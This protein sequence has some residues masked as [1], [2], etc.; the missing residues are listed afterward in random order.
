MAL[1]S[2]MEYIGEFD[3]VK[4]RYL[5]FDDS[6]KWHYWFSKNILPLFSQLLLLHVPQEYLLHWLPRMILTHEAR[7]PR[8][9]VRKDWLD[10]S[11][12]L[13]E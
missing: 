7:P 8:G 12:Q 10:F 6:Q 9:L 3:N 11:T 2:K 1:L 4:G 13:Q 5:E